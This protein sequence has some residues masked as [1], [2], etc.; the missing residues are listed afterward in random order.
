M[1]RRFA[2]SDR[3]L[4]QECL[5]HSD[6]RRTPVI[7]IKEFEIHQAVPEEKELIENIL[8]QAA[9]WIKSKGSKQWSGILGQ[10]N[11]K[12]NHDTLSAIKRGEVYFATIE[13]EPAGMF[14]MWD[15]QSEWDKTLWGN[16]PS[17]AFMYL[18]RLA[19]LRKYA[20]QGISQK[21][22]ESAIQIAKAKEKQAIRL[23][24]MSE[25]EYLNQL[26]KNAGFV[27]A[28]KVEDHDAGEQIADFNLYQYQLND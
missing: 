10:G 13:E 22:I 14:L 9:T 20:G 24:C 27:F 19:V 28:G 5:I 3:H 25:K 4:Q 15:H 26:Y 1:R 16:D 23:D 8:F 11:T 18:H 12:D 7:E 17:E 6:R 2:F 21:L